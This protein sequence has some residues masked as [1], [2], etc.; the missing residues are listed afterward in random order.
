MIHKHFT[1]VALLLTIV[2]IQFVSA[3]NYNP[4]SPP[5]T[6]RSAD[7]PKYWKNKGTLPADYWQQDVY[8]QMDVEIDEKTDIAHGT[9]KLTYWNN[10]P[11]TLRYV[12]FHLYQN[13]FQPGSYYEDL[14]LNNG[15]NPTYGPYQAQGLGTVVDTIFQDG[16]ALAIELDNTILK[17]YLN[18]PLFPGEYTTFDFDW[19]TYFDNSGSMRRRMKVF[20]T[21]GARQYNG[22]HWYPRLAVYDRKFGWTIDQHMDKEFYGDFGTYDVKLTF[23]HNYICEATGFLLNRSDMLPDTLRDLIDM[24]NFADKPWGEKPSIIIPYDSTKHKTW[25]YYAENIHDFAFT[26]NP[27]YRIGE[28]EWNGIKTYSI[29]LESHASGWQNA[30]EYTAAIVK[31]FSEDIGMYG[32]HK[33]IVAD[34]RDGMEYPMITMDN[35]KDPSYRGLLVHEVGHNWFYGMVNN[36]ETYR[37]SLDEGFTQFLTSWG[38]EKIDGEYLVQNAPKNWYKRAFWD[39]TEAR[40]ARVYSGYL[41]DAVRHQDKTLNRHSSDFETAVRQGGGYR[42]VYVKTSTMLYNLQYVLGDSLFLN[43]VQH[44]FDQ[45]SYAHPYFD[46][47]RQSFM[48]GSGNTDLNWFFDQ[49]LETTKTIDYKIKRVKE[50]KD[51]G[52]YTI[53]FKRK[54]EMQMPIEFQVTD[55]N[56]ATHDYLIPNTWFEKDFDGMI[57]DRWYGWGENI[58]PEYE[59]KIYIPAG[60]K[61]V[62]I[63]PSGRLADIN[64]LDNSYKFPLEW[65][66]ESQIYG[67]TN[68]DKYVARIRPDLWYNS[69]DGF[70]FGIHMNGSYMR[71]K[72]KFHFSMWWN[73]RLAQ[74]GFDEFPEE[75]QS[76]RQLMSFNAW[77]ETPLNKKANGTNIRAEAKILD[78]LYQGQVGFIKKWSPAWKTGINFKAF[79]RPDERDLQYLLYEDEWGLAQWNTSVN[80]WAERSYKFGLAKQSSGYMR[81]DF[82]S[83]SIASDYDYH[84]LSAELIERYQ[85]WRFEIAW[86]AYG[87][88]GTGSNFASESSLYMA[89]ANPEEMMDNKYVR[90]KAFLP[91][92]WVNQYGSTIGN[93]QYGGGLNLRGYNGYAVVEVDAQGNTVPAYKGSSGAAINV[94]FDFDEVVRVKNKWLRT[95]FDLDT[96]LFADGGAIVFDN[97][98]GN[99]EWS[100]FRLDA[101][102]GVAFTIK[103]WGVLQGLKPLTFRFDVPFYISHAPAAE[104]DNIAFRWL[105]TINRAF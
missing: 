28:A 44:Y 64:K 1:L 35:G 15:L 17:V 45:W 32:Y 86:R 87:Q 3:Q 88:I 14:W 66:F 71:Y 105:L 83:S 69:Y 30:A 85:V 27:H 39:S 12:F 33:M 100:D 60:I 25:H 23:A 36:N 73:S 34:A 84:V 104:P 41:Y 42:H 58:Q 13:A 53:T 19:K 55:R 96:Y 4:I 72:H 101:G 26:A 90:S 61:D 11:D 56:G 6:F 9:T 38:L 63:D 80:L 97:S 94:E 49:W 7:N 57:L 51:D 40:Y 98:I 77:Y 89:G 95:Y 65:E 52:W 82:R 5:N 21:Y 54:E 76:Q 18:T 43:S 8:Y 74:G 78:G 79:I 70:K 10:S 46:D 48:R 50:E 47:M 2:G 92:E 75:F 81:F 20:S 62:Q 91:P 68:P 29:A 24:G 59:A 67:N 37:A 102:A 22:C 16:K 103:K 31:V 93:F 99:R